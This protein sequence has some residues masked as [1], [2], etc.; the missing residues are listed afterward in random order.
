MGFLIKKG[1]K[2][3]LYYFLQIYFDSFCFKL[4]LIYV[5]YVI[6]RI[7]LFIFDYIRKLIIF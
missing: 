7:G 1:F 6:Y 5:I 2:M 4:N 3:C